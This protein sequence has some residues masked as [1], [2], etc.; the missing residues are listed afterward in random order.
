MQISTINIKKIGKILLL[1]LFFISAT[2]QAQ[3]GSVITLEEALNKAREN[4][5]SLKISQQQQ[6]IAKGQY[7]SSRAVLLPQLKLSNTSTL[8]NNPLQAFGFKLLQRNVT[9]ADFNP[10]LL[11]EPGNV[12]NYNT[13]IE[14]MQP[15]INVDGWKERKMANLNLEAKN[16]QYQRTTEYVELETMKTYMQLQLAHKSVYVLEKAKETALE[17]KAWAKLNFEQGLMQHA[18]YLDVQVRVADIELQLQTAR[19]NVQNVSDYLSFLTGSQETGA[20]LT[21]AE[22]LTIDP[23]GTEIEFM[24]D[25]NRKDLQVMRYNIE[26]QKQKLISSKM[27]FVPRANA[28][29]NYEW[30]DPT[31][32][33]FSANNYT[34]GLQLSW[35]IFDG[36]KS[37]GKVHE[38][39]ALLEKARLEQD[40]Y[41]KNSQME[42]NKTK[43]QYTDARNQLELTRLSLE[44]SKE[45]Y[46]VTENRYKQGLEKTK[47]LLAAESKYLEKELEHVSAIFNAN[48]SK[49]YLQFL[50]K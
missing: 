37:I 30:N 50:T 8:T 43:R 44:Q 13:R 42:I 33:G 23:S 20:I 11:N 45:A 34:V 29:A 26:V 46:R 28:M 17:N 49:I 18:D 21:P 41:I 32:T 22:E 14:L 39:K 36:Y 2:L 25:E 31:F 4:N 7:E 9:T 35:D 10:E 24:L 19:S 1:F 6:A 16:L 5:T 12:E 15:L 3:T 27:H 47:D 48:F 38:Q 40:Q